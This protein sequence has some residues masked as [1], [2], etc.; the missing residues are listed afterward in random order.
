MSRTTVQYLYSTATRYCRLTT[1]TILASEAQKRSLASGLAA[2]TG[3]IVSARE[4]KQQATTPTHIHPVELV[5]RH[6]QKA[7]S[8]SA[9][10]HT[11]C[12]LPTAYALS[13]LG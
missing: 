2:V 3:S 5:F 9:L 4:G 10:L 11:Y 7:L 6:F 8:S 12:M 13:Q 1:C